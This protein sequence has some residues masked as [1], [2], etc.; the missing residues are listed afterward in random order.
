MKITVKD[1]QTVFDIAIQYC[2]DVEAAF[3]I[4]QLNDISAT[5]DL[6]TGK[7]LILPDVANKRVADYYKNNAL[8]PATADRT[9]SAGEFI[10]AI[11]S[12]TDDIM[13]TNNDELIYIRQNN[14]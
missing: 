7:E 12:N 4:M 6:P 10:G 11:A 8:S 2:G 5:E 13:V 14:V 1:R 9:D 3:D